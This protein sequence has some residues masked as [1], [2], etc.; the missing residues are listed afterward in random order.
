MPR[1]RKPKTPPPNRE[2]D[3]L[4]IGSPEWIALLVEGCAQHG[5]AITPRQAA[6]MADH[7]RFLSDWNRKF[8]LTAI[9][10]PR[11]I[12]VKHFLDAILPAPWIPCQGP[13]LDIGTGGGFPGIPLK[14]MRPEQPVTLLDAS[15]KK[16]S[17][18]KYVIREL[19]LPSADAVQARAEALGNHP[20][21]RGRYHVVVTRAVADFATVVRLSLPLLA[22]GGWIV[23]YKGPGENPEPDPDLV[24]IA[25]GSGSR[26]GPVAVHAYTLPCTGDPRRLVMVQLTKHLDGN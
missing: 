3:T 16:I 5:I 15:R 21:H 4:R 1:R 22:P 6:Y 26:L 19:G 10:E 8:N 20:E 11:Q 18:I 12:A 17:F 13:L 24:K 23:L 7:G 25:T 9:T 2:P 14:I